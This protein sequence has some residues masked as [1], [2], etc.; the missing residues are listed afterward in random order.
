[1]TISADH[2]LK[3]G[4]TDIIV[5]IHENNSLERIPGSVFVNLH[6]D[7]N[8]S[9]QATLQV[10]EERGGRLIELIHPNDVPVDLRERPKIN[11]YIVFRISGDEHYY[12]ADP[13]RIFT[14]VGRKNDIYLENYGSN[15]NA[16][17]AVETFSDKLLRDFI[18]EGIN[19]D[20]IIAVH[21]NTGLDLSDPS[22]IL[23]KKDGQT[24]KNEP[25]TNLL[26]NFL[27]VTNEN[28]YTR[29]VNQNK[30]NVGLQDNGLILQNR[31]SSNYNDGSI[32]VY[33]GIVNKIPY[34]NVEVCSSYSNALQYQVDMLRSVYTREHN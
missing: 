4:R 28:H 3:L 34:I 14:D 32:S 11:R 5:R 6:D 21:N 29:F 31:D 18:L 27:L 2:N 24:E 10:I 13:N 30:Y 7:E 22:I 15:V 17:Q 1:M 19:T 16:R 33:C 23:K 8:I 25:Q 9:V 20:V 12:I 26:S